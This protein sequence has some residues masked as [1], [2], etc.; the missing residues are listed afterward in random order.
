MVAQFRLLYARSP[1]ILVFVVSMSPASRPVF[2]NP[3]WWIFTAALACSSAA[4][5]PP[6]LQIVP[7]P[8][9]PASGLTGQRVMVLPLETIRNGDPL[10]WYTNFTDTAGRTILVS[11]NTAIAHALTTMAPRTV[12]LMPDY[13]EK[14]SARNAQYAPS[15]YTMDVSQFDPG[16]HH[17][18]K[19]E[20]PLAEDLRTLTSFTDARVALVPAEVRFVPWPL[21]TYDKDTGKWVAAAGPVTQ[22]VAVLRVALVDS[23]FVVVAWLGDVMSDPSTTFTP[24]VLTSLANHLG[25]A[26]SRQ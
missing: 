19:L 11:A 2:G 23:R 6:D 20:D 15:P 3:W 18:G 16:R 8:A 5:P 24:A 10:G 14:I 17:S 12:W 7:M 25:E 13:L 4:P 9:S 1:A 22:E 26:L 21:P